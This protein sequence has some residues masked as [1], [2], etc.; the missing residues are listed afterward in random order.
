M[1]ATRWSSHKD[2]AAKTLKKLA[3]PHVP[4]TLTRLEQTV[5]RAHAA[6]EKAETAAREQQRAERK[7]VAGHEPVGEE[8]DDAL[9]DAA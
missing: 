2:I 6:Y 7:Q 3:G 8:P 9:D 5:K 1:P 4:A